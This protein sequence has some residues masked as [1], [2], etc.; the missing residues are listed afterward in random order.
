MNVSNMVD[1]ML[2]NANS[3][4][5]LAFSFGYARK[6]RKH[7]LNI[8]HYNTFSRLKTIAHPYRAHTK[9]CRYL[10]ADNKLKKI[11]RDCI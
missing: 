11:I 4:Y 6:D 7:R 8:Q 10:R 3:S 2:D 5:H 9:L 1:S